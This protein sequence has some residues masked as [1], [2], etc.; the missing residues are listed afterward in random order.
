MTKLY[1]MPRND[2]C[3]A[4]FL[5]GNFPD[6]L[7]RELFWLWIIAFSVTL[8]NMLPLPI[9]DGDRMVKEFVNWGVGEKYDTKRKKKD[10]F[11]YKKQENFYGLSEYR[12]EKV[13]SI[14]IF[15]K[16]SLNGEERS[17][18]I[19]G[20]KNYKLIDKIGDGYTSTIQFDLPEQRELPENSIVEVSY[21]HWYDEK[22]RQ[23]RIILN[24]IRLVTLFII[25][26]NFIL[27]FIHLGTVAFWLS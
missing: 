27:S 7:L 19:L 3:V 12:V 21:E 26:G 16:E 24:V 17:E 2:N 15:T 11:L 13:D 23:K 10:S 1:W 8:F 6:F 9:F 18:I 5:G 22:K 14:K 20:E 25:L 4:K